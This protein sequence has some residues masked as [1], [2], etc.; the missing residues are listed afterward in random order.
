MNLDEALRQIGRYLYGV[1]HHERTQ[2]V[3]HSLEALDEGSGMEMK[4]SRRAPSLFTLSGRAASFFRF[5]LNNKLSS[6][7][8]QGCN[9]YYHTLY[10][11]AHSRP[12]ISV[13]RT[14]AR[15]PFGGCT[16]K[17]MNSSTR[18]VQ[19]T[20]ESAPGSGVAFRTA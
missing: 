15:Q 5:F 14:R 4:E 20:S 9:Q 3:T 12:Q 17:A 6:G 13:V 16:P 19:R 8:K 10:C 11:C 2:R 18:N 1:Q 7:E